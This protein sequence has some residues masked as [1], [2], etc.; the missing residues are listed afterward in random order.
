MPNNTSSVFSDDQA[1]LN[2]KRHIVIHALKSGLGSKLLTNTQFNERYG[3]V[4]GTMQRA[5]KH[6]KDAMALTTQ[7]K[8]HMGRIVTQI[9]TG[10]CWNI[11]K[12]DPVQLI[13]PSSG[14][15]EI[16]TLIRHI[17]NKLSKLNI[18]YF[19]EHQPGGELRISQVLSGKFDI[20]LVSLGAAKNMPQPIDENNIKMLAPGTYYS[21]NR[22]VVV[23]EKQNNSPVRVAIDNNSSDHVRLTEIEFP[24]SDGFKY[25]E[26]D[27]RQIPARILSK[28]A[29]IGLWHM[30][31][32]PVSLEYAGLCAKLL[33]K[34]ESITSHRQLSAATLVINPHRPELFALLSEVNNNEIVQ[35]QTIAFNQEDPYRKAFKNIG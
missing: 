33:S 20:A 16:D 13:M 27:F 8:G 9:D 32:S 3:I 30:T 29:D 23:S 35:S 18:P 19:I 4:A 21:M 11:A 14:S 5:L 12:L 6:L 15:I 31:S 1:I 22:L 7:S 17:T 25:V 24:K 2:A 10:L 34:Q 26:T 28:E